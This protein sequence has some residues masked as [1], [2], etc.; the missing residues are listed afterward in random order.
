MD[1]L[2]NVFRIG[3]DPWD[4]EDPQFRDWPAPCDPNWISE[5]WTPDP[6]FLE[7]MAQLVLRDPGEFCSGYFGPYMY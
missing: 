2:W 1:L 4:L 5:R 6:F 3:F 7:I